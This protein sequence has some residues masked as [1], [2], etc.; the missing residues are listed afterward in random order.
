[1]GISK[2]PTGI[3]LA[4]LLCGGAEFSIA[5]PIGLWTPHGEVQIEK[6]N[7][8]P[9]SQQLN[10]SQA[11]KIQSS[12]SGYAYAVFTSVPSADERASIERSG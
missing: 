3:V 4:L 1:M 10:L 2:S 12:Q 6:Y 11:K 9:Q 5:K 7:R 8:N